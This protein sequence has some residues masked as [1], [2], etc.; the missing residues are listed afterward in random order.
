MG[1]KSM[2]TIQKEVLTTMKKRKKKENRTPVRIR[3]LSLSKI[4][5]G[6][7]DAYIS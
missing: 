4:I 5:T 3:I 7:F 2:L 1:K 6:K